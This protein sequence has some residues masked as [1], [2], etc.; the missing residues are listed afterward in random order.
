[1]ENLTYDKW[2]GLCKCY[3]ELDDNFRYLRKHRKLNKEEKLLYQKRLAFISLIIKLK[4][5]KIINM[6][7]KRDIYLDFIKKWIK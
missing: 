2:V 4:S 1:M 3:S 5:P 6:D 7:I